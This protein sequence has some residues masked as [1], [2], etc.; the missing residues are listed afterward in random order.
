MGPGNSHNLPSRPKYAFDLK[1]PSWTDGRGSQESYYSNVVLWKSM[2]DKLPAGHGIK[3]DPQL[4]GI[5]L[6]SQLFARAA[7]LVKK[8]SEED[9]MGNDGALRIARVIYK[10]DPLTVLTYSFSKFQSLLN[11]RRGSI[12]TFRN[13]ESRF[14]AAVSS[15]NAA[16]PSAKLSQSLVAFLLLAN[17]AVDDNHRIS[18]LAAA[19]P[20]SS[21]PSESS[22]GSE[23]TPMDA[24]GNSRL[25]QELD[26]ESVATVLRSCDT[27]KEHSDSANSQN[28]YPGNGSGALHS[29][30]ARTSTKSRRRMTKEEII[31]LKKKSRCRACE[32]FGHW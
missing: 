7:D 19:V 23:S 1:N 25:L 26:Y 17:A 10:T 21:S 13:F 27:V 22:S 12:E 6:K 29:N 5:V 30:A 3:I 20:K 2:H 24:T 14:D 31:E 28:R 32:E 11:T 9:I 8:L 15:F 18:I 16:S 4:Q